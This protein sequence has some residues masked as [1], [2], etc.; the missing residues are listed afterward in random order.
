M[1]IPMGIWGQNELFLKGE[2]V[3][4]LAWGGCCPLLQHTLDRMPF[5]QKSTAEK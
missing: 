2:H 3:Q 4:S 1:L 5:P